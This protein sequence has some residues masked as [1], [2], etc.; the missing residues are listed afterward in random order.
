[1]RFYFFALCMYPQGGLLVAA[2]PACQWSAWIVLF[3]KTTGWRLH[4][5]E[6]KKK[7]LCTHFSRANIHLDFFIEPLKGRCGNSSD[8]PKPTVNARFRCQN[9]ALISRRLIYEL[10]FCSNHTIIDTP[11]SSSTAPK[12]RR[13]H[14][15]L[16]GAARVF[17]QLRPISVTLHV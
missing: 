14:S 13:S 10:C 12:L 17:P 9:T 16:P 1:M 5:L 6:G 2:R 3:S 11:Q 7:W 4:G 15:A 8:S